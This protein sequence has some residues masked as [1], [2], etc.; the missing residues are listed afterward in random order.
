MTDNSDNVP[1]LTDSD[2]RGLADDMLGRLVKSGA[3]SDYGRELVEW[4]DGF[5]ERNRHLWGE[6][7]HANRVANNLGAVLGECLRAAY[8]GNWSFH[9]Q[10]GEWGI[11][12]GSTFGTVFPAAKVYKQ[13]TNGPEDSI[14]SLFDVVGGIIQAGGIEKLRS[15]QKNPKG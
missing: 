14:L 11:D 3:S 15:A 12:L 4:L 8:G 7:E 13:V 10:F 1:Q 6:E 5:I 2:F 9:E